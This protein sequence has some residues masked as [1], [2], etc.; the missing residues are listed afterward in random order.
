MYSTVYLL[1]YTLTEPYGLCSA[2]DYIA[3]IALLDDKIHHE[4]SAP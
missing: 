4:L 2:Q 3:Y 1:L